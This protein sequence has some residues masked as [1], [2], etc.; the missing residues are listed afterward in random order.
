[1]NLY[2]KATKMKDIFMSGN[3]EVTYM[4]VYEMSGRIRGNGI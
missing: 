1:M 2:A 4:Y 3:L